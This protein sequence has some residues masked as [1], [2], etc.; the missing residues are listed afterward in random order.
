MPPD[1][2]IAESHWVL[3]AHALTAAYVTPI[4]AITI[5]EKRCGKSNNLKVVG[6]MVPRALLAA[7]ITPRRGLPHGGQVPPDAPHRRGRH[8]LR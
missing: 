4:L 8:V 2:V 7:N 5:P 3:H 6:A 1:A